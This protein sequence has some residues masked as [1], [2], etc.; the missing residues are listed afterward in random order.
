MGGIYKYGQ[1]NLTFRSNPL[2]P[3]EI[4]R[5]HGILTFCANFLC[6]S[7]LGKIL[8]IPILA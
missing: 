5:L 4:K 3:K 7:D 8:T 6:L 1:N 2:C